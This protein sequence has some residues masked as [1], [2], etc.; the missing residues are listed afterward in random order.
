MGDKSLTSDDDEKSS[1]TSSK[2]SAMQDFLTNLVNKIDDVSANQNSQRSKLNGPRNQREDGRLR[3][4]ALAVKKGE[5][6]LP[7]IKA[8]RENI[9]EYD[10][11]RD[12]DQAQKDVVSEVKKIYPKL[13]DTLARMLTLRVPSKS[14]KG[15]WQQQQRPYQALQPQQ[16]QQPHFQPVQQQV[17]QQPQ[18]VL[19]QPQLYQTQVQLQP[20]TFVQPQP[21]AAVA[22]SGPKI[23]HAGMA[24]SYC[25]Y[26]FKAGTVKLDKC[27]FLKANPTANSTWVQA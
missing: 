23:Q 13:A 9:E 7:M 5:D 17:L 15:S 24:G 12:Y 19:Q 4:V 10:Q 3:A 22:V 25:R 1:V 14:K 26:C 16:L 8:L 20:Q 6:F 21:Q 27:N 2:D 11:H 18:Q